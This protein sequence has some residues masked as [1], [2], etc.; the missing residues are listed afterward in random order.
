MEL[1]QCIY[2]SASTNA[3]FRPTD[4]NALL[5]ECRVKNAKVDVTGMLLYHGGTF[6]QV[7]EGDRGVVEPLFEMIGRD[8]RHN[9]ITKIVVEPIEERAFGAWTMGYSNITAK[10]LTSLPGV[11]D[12]FARGR[13]YLE[14][15]E[16]R[17]KSLLVAF[18][19]GK[20]R[21]SLS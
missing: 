4:L 20:W 21:L 2:C 5:D 17:A 6:F 14:L 18:K 3:A 1:V 8:K 11:N 7:L 16:S 19:E 12:F 9:R 15:S 10:E 13:S